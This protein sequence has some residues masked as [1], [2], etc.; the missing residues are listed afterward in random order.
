[1]EDPTETPRKA[2][3]M[4]LNAE[5]PDRAKLEAEHGDVWSTAEMQ[6]D[7]SVIGF[8]APF[9]VVTRKSDQKKGSLM[10]T[11]SPRFYFGFTED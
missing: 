9:I 8:M 11:H 2:L 1:M 7:F 6:K 3:T 5:D 4:L 10:F